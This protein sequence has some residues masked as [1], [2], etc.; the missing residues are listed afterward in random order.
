MTPAAPAPPFDPPGLDPRLTALLA[1][2][3]AA[4]FSERLHHSIE[5]MER[6]SID[7]SIA[8]LRRLGVMERLADWRGAA[9]LCRSMTFAPRFETALAW[10][11]ERLLETGGIT[12]R[13]RDGVRQYRLENALWEPAL[14]E[15][16]AAGIA[17]DPANRATLNLLDHAAS[18]YPAVAHGET[19]GEQALFGMH[20]IP[21]WLEYFHDDNTTYAINNWL[22]ALAAADCVSTLP[23]IRIL[24]FGAGAGS[25]SQTLLRTLSERGLASRIE[26]YVITEPNAFFRRR[27][28]RSLS[29]QYAELPLEF[30]ALDIDKPWDKQGVAPGGFHLI[31][32]INALHVANDLVFSLRQ[33]RAS[34]T[35]DGWLVAGECLRL[36]ARQPIYAELMFQLLEGFSEV[37]TDPQF[38]PN[39][40]FLT[41]SQWRSAFKRAGFGNVE[42]RPDVERIREI[43]PHFFTGAVCGGI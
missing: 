22:G 10:L 18:I 24:E 27:S 36:F 5:L 8:L 41:P 13:E 34:L 40:G 14:A 3:P 38:R 21:L 31:Y 35:A 32:G 30:R 19:T 20:G 9:D 2:Y 28:Q 6:Y 16:R 29:T 39:G 43:Y 11:L 17:I 25:A 23:A 15:L 33:A 1:Q 26:R 12:V 37:N 4:L 7:W 42:V